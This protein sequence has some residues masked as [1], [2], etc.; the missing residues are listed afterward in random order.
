MKEV[1]APKMNKNLVL[2]LYLLLLA[3]LGPLAFWLFSSKP[4]EFLN[5]NSSA[6][7]ESPTQGGAMMNSSAAPNQLSLGQQI[8]VT[9]D[10]LPEKQ[11][12]VTAYASSDYK[13]A[14]IKFTSS[15]QNNRNDPE[16]L[17]YLNNA[18][19]AMQGKAI[20]IGVSVPV[21]GNLNVA[22]EILRGVAQAQNEV[23]RSGGIEGKLLQVEIA[24][25][26][27]VP[28]I[29]KQI[30]TQFVKDDSILAVI[31]HNA[32]EA[33]IA[34]APIYQQAGLVMISP[35]SVARNLS[36][37]GSYIFRTTPSSKAMASML[38]EY[39]VKSARKTKVAICFASKTE[40]SQS[41]QEEFTT[42]VFEN[43]GQAIKARCDF[44]DPTFDASAVPTQVIS[45][46]AEALVLA[47]PLN[48][49]NHAIDVLQ[50]AKRRLPIFGSQTMYSIETLK[51]GQGD[52]NGIVLAVPWHPALATGSTFAINAKKLWGG[53]GSWRTAMAYDATL[54]VI[55]GL[56]FGQS[57]DLVQKALSNS[58][59]SVKGVT[60][61][62]QFLPSGDRLM[63]VTLVKVQ[64]GKTSGT[65]Y[66]FVPLKAASAAPID[67]QP[68][69]S[70]NF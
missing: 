4:Q 58:G 21:G 46:G 6:P 53:S 38:A 25:D 40:A 24:N 11:A 22:R 50:A 3:F 68:S 29:A 61:T 65:S 30:A 64:P 16:S 48:G 26:N 69:S 51:Q 7:K 34:A 33:S 42:A 2:T 9:E 70:P 13:T 56:K 45:D 32:S 41:F 57:R 35:T 54:A 20:K 52:A 10:N 36:G 23:N 67:A 18:T 5:V 27:N 8:L 28:E 31:G 55:S 17:I 1:K 19:A 63:K 14:A 37:I 62:V 66:D 59:F 49:V 15:L 12:A 43:G 60:G 47:P 44:S 39:I